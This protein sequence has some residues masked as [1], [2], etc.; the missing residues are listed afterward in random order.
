MR[1]KFLPFLLSLLFLLPAISFGQTMPFPGLRSIDITPPGFPSIGATF[2]IIVWFDPK[3]SLVI[4]KPRDVGDGYSFFRILRTLIDRSKTENFFIEFDEG[5]S[6]DPR[7]IIYPE[8]GVKWS[9]E[10][11]GTTLI[12]PG[13]GFLYVSGHTNNCFDQRKKFALK[14]TEFVE[15]KQPF[16]YVGIESRALKDLAITSKQRSG[17]V[18]AHIPKGEKVTIILNED[19]CY[20]L[21]T[22]FGLLGWVRLQNIGQEAE[23]LEGIFFYGD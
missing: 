23:V 17:E 2:P 18:V 8:K 9:A 14:E 19:E 7:F 11:P 12:I 1:I 3:V 22:Q 13:N 5:P 4:N 21:K 6:L 20:L 10:F 15:I 16:Y